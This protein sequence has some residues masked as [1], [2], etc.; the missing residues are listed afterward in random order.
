M[1]KCTRVAYN[2]FE[3]KY[4]CECGTLYSSKKIT[5][6]DSCYSKVIAKNAYSKLHNMDLCNEQCYEDI[7]KKDMGTSNE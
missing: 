4:Y 2:S 7:L 6:C 5:Y 1:C 3:D